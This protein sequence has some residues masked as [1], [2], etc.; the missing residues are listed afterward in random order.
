MPA[1]GVVMIIAVVL[2]VL[3]IV[4]YLVSTIV[5][6]RKI[7]KALDEAITGVVGIIEKSAPVADV[8]GDINTNLDAGVDLLEGLLVKKAGLEDAVGLVDGLYP[9]A[10]RDGL[11]NFPDS[12]SV[13]APRISEVYTK[14][15]LTLARLGREA[16]IAAASPNGP[17]L[18]NVERGSLM[19]R[20]LYPEIAAVATGRDAALAGDRHR[21]AG[22]VRAERG[23]RSPPHDAGRPT[24]RDQLMQTPAPCDYE[25]ATS[26]DGAIASLQRVGSGAR[27]IAGGHSLIP[28]MKLRLATPEHL[29]DINDLARALLHPRARRR[30]QDRRAHPPRRA[31]RVRAAR[32]EAAGVPRRRGGDRRSGRAQPRHDR[33]LAVPGRPGRGPERRLLGAEGHGGDQRR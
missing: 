2:I 13:K 23:A 22:P 16:P 9:G 27:I 19:A 28:M 3:A 1:A 7:T 26:V 12:T 8:V 24:R 14:G 17:A 30:D 31:A 32:R 25:R 18:R 29:I 11:R 21:L 20:L 5:A 33:R 10:A 4:V 6:L 15:T